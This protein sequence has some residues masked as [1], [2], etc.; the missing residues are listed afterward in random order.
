MA[1]RESARFEGPV[2]MARLRC[3]NPDA[4][5]PS[6]S[7]QV[8]AVGPFN[9]SGALL[10]A[11]VTIE[12]K[13]DNGAV[14]SDTINLTTPAPAGGITAVT[15]AELVTALTSAA[16]TN[17]T[18]SVETATGRLLLALTTPGAA[19][20]LQIG[21]EV[22]KFAGFGYGFGTEFVK[23]DTQ[24]SVAQEPV[25]K[26]SERLEVLDSS[27]RATAIITRGYRMGSNITVTD[28][29]MDINLRAMLEGG[30]FRDDSYTEEAYVAPGSSSERP[31]IEIEWF[32]GVYGKDDSNE[33]NRI[34]YLWRKCKSAMLS[35]VGGTA[36][37]RNIQTG[38]YTLAVTPYKDPISSADN[39]AD[40]VTQFLTVSEF[41]ALHVLTV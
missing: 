5:N 18:A 25:S 35:S 31:S 32:S 30:T 6:V 22:A 13:T 34:G 36:G 12:I 37:D 17:L 8:S 38:V 2:V 41:D 23:L 39:E 33:S 40:T 9:F 16:V 7:R 19:K 27:G 14:V 26:D 15:A 24:Q 4:G 1:L 3:S 28:V 20:Y 11:A 10:P 29:A 21:G